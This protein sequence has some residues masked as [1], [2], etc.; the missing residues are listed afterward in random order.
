MT[1]RNYTD[2]QTLIMVSDFTLV[3]GS[4]HFGSARRTLIP[5]SERVSR[6]PRGVAG[7]QHERPEVEY[8]FRGR[9]GID[10]TRHPHTVGGGRPFDR[11]LRR[12]RA[13]TPRLPGT[14]RLRRCRRSR[15]GAKVRAG[16]DRPRDHAAWL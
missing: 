8:R 9:L 6:T 12:A 5:L 10:E 3:A 1:V 16:V 7:G 14:V 13:R 4:L 11:Q 15:G 2:F